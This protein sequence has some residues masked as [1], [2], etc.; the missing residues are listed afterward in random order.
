MAGEWM[1][2]HP[3]LQPL[4]LVWGRWELPGYRKVLNRVASWDPMRPAPR[5][6]VRGKLH[7]YLMD[8]DLED[9]PE[10][11]AYFLGRYYEAHTQRLFE[12][13]L[14]P[15]DVFVD[16]G[17]NIG[18]TAL[19][20]AR[21]VGAGGAGRVLCFEPN[22]VAMARLRGHVAINGLE[23]LVECRGMGLAETAGELV[24]HVPAHS[25][26]A[27]FAG[28]RSEEEPPRHRDTEGAP[29]GEEGKAGSGTDAGTGSGTRFGES[30]YP[31]RDLDQDSAMR[32]VRVPVGVGD[33]QLAGERDA[34]MFIKIDVEGFELKVLRG[35]QRTLEAR[36]PAVLTEAIPALLARAG[37]SLVALARFMGDRG[38][39]AWSVEYSPAL[40][41]WPGRLILRRVEVA[42]VVAG[43]A[44]GGGAE[45]TGAMS[46]DVLWLPHRDGEGLSPYAERLGHAGVLAQGNRSPQ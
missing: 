13:V 7:G 23:R 14:R 24:L 30:R 6:R 21:Q 43:V 41:G 2:M 10:R 15:G 37:D 31:E 16:V 19:V 20:A 18:M 46:D 12:V 32:H 36:R 44:G 3:M 29:R 25:G 17:A 35:L 22:P 8:L 40:V 28:L 27:S 5:K 45:G 39:T 9:W 26:Q 42:S 33:E 4:A 34:P 11:W 38:Y 1:F